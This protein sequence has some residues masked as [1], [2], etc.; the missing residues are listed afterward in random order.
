MESK[1]RVFLADSQVLFR[2]GMH[3]VLEGEEEGI[4]VV[5]EGTSAEEAL[6]FL[7]N[8]TVDV[9]ILSEDM[10]DRARRIKF[11]F[12][13]VRLIFVG[14]SYLD[15]WRAMVGAGDSIFLSRDMDPSELVA[16]VKKAG[17]SNT[18]SAESSQKA[19]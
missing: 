18:K 8:E 16:A 5:G 13:A 1:I 12:P 9:L 17:R 6:A 4:Q 11:T 14:N 2:E 10:R 19:V 7:G 3:F 15:D